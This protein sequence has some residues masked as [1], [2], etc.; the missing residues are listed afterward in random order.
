[1]S[2]KKRSDENANALSVA[3]AMQ[4]V[5]WD[6]VPDDEDSTFEV[7]TGAFFEEFPWDGEEAPQTKPPKGG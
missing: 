6:F 3:Q 4:L 7:S 1:M 5:R 2:A